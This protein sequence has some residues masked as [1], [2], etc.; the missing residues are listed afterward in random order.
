MVH[1][2]REAY[3]KKRHSLKAAFEV[4][5][6]RGA[7]FRPEDVQEARAMLEWVHSKQKG[8]EGGLAAILGGIGLASPPIL[9]RSSRRSFTVRQAR[10]TDPS[11]V[12][13]TRS[14][15]PHNGRGGAS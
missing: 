4:I 15:W 3:E 7:D 5:E 6:Q 2:A 13:R 1:A 10:R 12:P 9:C 14:V 11:L 8:R